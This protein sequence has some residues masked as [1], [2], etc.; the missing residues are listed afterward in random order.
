[1]GKKGKNKKPSTATTA[2]ASPAPKNGTE[3]AKE[4]AIADNEPLILQEPKAE[5][6][7]EQ[8]SIPK[9]SE[10]K[11]VGKKIKFQQNFP[12]FLSCLCFPQ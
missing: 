6:V 3:V 12:H 1:M 10:K 8:P 2:G 5:V 11:P 7:L 4:V 9:P